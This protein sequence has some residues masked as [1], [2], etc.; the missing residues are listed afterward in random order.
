MGVGATKRLT[1]VRWGVAR[2]IVIAWIFT[3]PMCIA[4]AWLSYPIIVK[5][6]E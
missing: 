1:A 5:I 3:L 2:K 4:I 6:L